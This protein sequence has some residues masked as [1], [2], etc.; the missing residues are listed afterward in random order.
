MKILNIA[1]YAIDTP[2]ALAPGESADVEASE[3][4]QRQIEAGVIVE[5]DQPTV[6]KSQ[7][8]VAQDTKDEAK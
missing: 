5:V 8:P 7:P 4:T 1:P 3:E 2:I 6:V